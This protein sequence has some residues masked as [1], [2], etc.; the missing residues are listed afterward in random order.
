MP[1][2]SLPKCV[3][4]LSDL[5]VPIEKISPVIKQI[6]DICGKIPNNLPSTRT[7]ERMIDSK[8][9]IAHKQI[10]NVLSNKID[11]TL[12]TDETRKYG[13]T[14][15]TYIVTDDNKT[16]YVLGL[17]EMLDKSSK[18]CLDT[19]KEIL[20]DITDHCYEQEKDNEKQAGYELLCH[21]KNTMSDRASTEK[22]FNV[23]L[24]NFRREILPLII[25]DWNKLDVTEQALCSKMNNFFCGLHLMVGIADV[26]EKA[27][28][29]FEEAFLEGKDIGS[30]H[31]PELKRFY[32]HE[33]GTLRL[34]RT[35]CKV[36]A[37]GEDEKSGAS[38]A[39][40]T[41]LKQQGEKNLFIRFKHN[42]FNLVF[43]LGLAC[44]FHKT[45]ASIFLDTVHGTNNGL[46]RAVSLDIKEDLY[47]AGCKSFGL[48]SKLI[49]GPLWR[50]LESPGHILEMNKFYKQVIDFL[51]KGVSDTELAVKFCNGTESPFDTDISTDDKLLQDLVKENTDVDA[52]VVPMVQN[53]FQAIHELLSR[54]IIDH[55]PGGTFWEPEEYTLLSSK[56]ALKHNRLP[57]FVFGQ[58]DQLLRYRPNAT[59]LTNES[60]IMYSHNKTRHWLASLDEI[61]KKKLI[62]ESMKEG[63]EQ[64][65][66]FRSRLADIQIQ[67]IEVQKQKQQQLQ[68]LER[69]RIQKAEDMTNM[70]CYYGLWQNQNQLEEGLSVLKSEKEKRAAL[71]AQLKF[72]KTVL[73]QKHPD[74]KIYNFS[75][76]NERGKY[77]KLTIQQ[78]KDN[79]ET[80]IK[81]TLKEPTHEN[82]TQGRPLLVGKT[83]KHSFSDGNIYNGYV[84]SM[85]PG[86]SMW[87]NIK[88]ER[89]DAIYAFNLV[90]DMEKGDLSIVV[91]NQ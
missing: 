16:S 61:E 59:V 9:A 57:E 7:I 51:V 84:I 63:K 67:R 33:S 10:S 42:R 85:V 11:T 65:Q 41:F 30:A 50:L 53:L 74:K 6:A 76:L 80:L 28:Y 62:T 71:E 82:A 29:K 40:M 83:I 79:V 47:L 64:R 32:R 25:E 38:M 89:D 45:L 43:V 5:K 4:N 8:I 87:Y 3:I 39:W 23:L 78:L 90:E 36:F 15:Q 81:D 22:A 1:K 70:V 77:T 68:E 19:F 26:C 18:S 58:L 17:R 60:F 66:L 88:Y 46:L 34:I 49:T 14:L 37:V 27:L 2:K 86:F 31:Y 56:S 24:E 35:A 13:K 91:A 54:L 12:Y 55:L 75:K 21:L 69:K 52:I 48:I 20:K 72:R 73:K 44:Y